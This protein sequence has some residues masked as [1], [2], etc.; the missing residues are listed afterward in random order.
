MKEVGMRRSTAY[1]DTRSP[2]GHRRIAHSEML[3]ATARGLGAWLG[4]SLP[5]ED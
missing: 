5:G 1:Y 4:V 2:A 3:S